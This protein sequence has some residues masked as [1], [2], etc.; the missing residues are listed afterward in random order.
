[1]TKTKK[2]IET[3][4]HIVLTDKNNNCG[5]KV[6]NNT[7][8]TTVTESVVQYIKKF[9]DCNKSFTELSINF[10]CKKVK[11]DIQ[12]ILSKS[13]KYYRKLSPNENIESVDGLYNE[14][15]EVQKHG[16]IW[17]K[18][19]ICNIYGATNEEVKNI[20]YNSQYDLPAKYNRLDNCNISVKTT[21][22]TSPHKKTTVCMADC[23][24][25]FDTVSSGQPIHMVVIHYIQET[26]NTKKIKKIIEIDLTYSH[27]LLFGTITRSQ[28][29]ELD[30]AIKSVPTKRRI[31]KQESKKLKSMRDF[32]H[33]TRGAI[34]LNIKIDSKYQRRLQ[35]SFN[36]FDE[37]VEKNPTKILAKSNT[38]KFRGGEISSQIISETRKFNK[39]KSV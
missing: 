35:C 27:D 34:Y 22:I 39:K 26:S 5:K 24:N 25:L 30:K 6:V 21:K 37:F 7:E 9:L 14:S 29:E 13:N 4:Q 32:L 17:E 16:F 12:E 36:D 3:C 38:N 31:T 11:D 20:K 28:I 10:D 23:L 1:M 15:K 19:I 8:K 33:E 18:E 2:V